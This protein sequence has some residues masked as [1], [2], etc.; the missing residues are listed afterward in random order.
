MGPSRSAPPSLP[1]DTVNVAYNQTLTASGGTG[2]DTLTVTNIQNAITGLVGPSGGSN[3]L[4]IT[5]T[6]MAAGT[7]T[8]TVTATDTLGATAST[9]YSITVN[10]PVSLGPASLPADTVNVAYNQTLTAS[11]GTGTDTLTVTNIQN[12][13]T[14][15]VVPSGGSN[16]L[17]ITGT[18]TATGTETF[19]VTAADTLG[20]TASTD[21][22]I[23]VNDPTWNG[24]ATGNLSE[25]ANWVAGVAPNP[26]IE[27]LV[28]GGSTASTPFNDFPA[29][30]AISW[31]DLQRWLYPLRQLR[32]VGVDDRQCPGEQQ[33][34]APARARRRWAFSGF[35]GLPGGRWHDRQRRPSAHRQY[36]G[37]SRARSSAGRSPARAAWS[38]AGPGP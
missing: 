18:P 37:Q 25:S 11:G 21:Y 22:S 35:I 19:T 31:P 33:R 8:F 1:A 20:A 10:G 12:A 26:A 15:L 28:L 30:G 27:N 16:S 23:T 5:G 38:R 29:G 9:D 36:G 14:G 24:N 17:S 32:P 13:I 34:V 4:S 7:E 2:T 6:P 3:S